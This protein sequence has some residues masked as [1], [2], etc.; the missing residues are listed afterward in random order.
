MSTTKNPERDLEIAR[1][2][3]EGETYEELAKAYGI[4]VSRI[5]QI[6]A[7]A[8]KSGVTFNH[9]IPVAAE[10][11]P[12]APGIPAAVRTSWPHVPLKLDA[13]LLRN[14]A[15]AA[16]TQPPIKSPNSQMTKWR[17]IAPGSNS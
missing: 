1:R 11:E 10:P 15:R 7:T 6:C 3:Y 9:P 16:Q 17:D 13:G 5:G 14:A 8:Y 12:Q 4:S 2:S